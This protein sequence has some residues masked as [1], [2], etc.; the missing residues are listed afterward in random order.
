MARCQTGEDR[1][2]NKSTDAYDIWKA[3][4]TVD[5]RAEIYK[6]LEITSRS[7]PIHE[8][9]DLQADNL[10]ML[11]TWQETLFL[12]VDANRAPFAATG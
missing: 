2:L 8:F 11:S 6:Q 9:G 7:G 3:M 12:D 4:W 5:A 10:Y 1:N